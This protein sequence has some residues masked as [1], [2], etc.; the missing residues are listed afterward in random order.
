MFA[1]H[2]VL[3]CRPNHGR[4][5]A[6]DL[7]GARTRPLVAGL[8]WPLAGILDQDTPGPAAAERK[9]SAGELIQTA[10]GTALV[11]GRCGFLFEPLARTCSTADSILAWF[12]GLRASS[13]TFL[14]MPSA[15]APRMSLM[16]HA[17][18]MT[19]GG[20]PRPL[21]SIQGSCWSPAP[22]HSGQQRLDLG[23][24][25]LEVP[26][27]RR[28]GRVAELS[29]E[30]AFAA[31]LDQGPLG[32]GD[33]RVD[34]RHRR[35]GS[36]RRPRRQPPPRG[37]PRAARRTPRGSRARSS[38]GRSTGPVPKHCQS[39]ATTSSSR[40]ARKL[41]GTAS[42]CTR[43][44]DPS[45]QRSSQCRLTL[46]QLVSDVC[47]GRASQRPPATAL[48]GHREAVV[49]QTSGS[50][51]AD[52]RTPHGQTVPE[53][54]PRT[55]RSA[56]RPPS[57][58]SRRSDPRRPPRPVRTGRAPG[59]VPRRTGAQRHLGLAPPVTRVPGV[60]KVWLV[61]R[62]SESLDDPAP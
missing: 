24:L 30:R 15:A 17:Y 13:Y 19:A 44:T 28:D 59:R 60:E 43:P 34:R 50:R 54:E 57:L 62:G 2:V 25:P 16:E 47:Q 33:H 35:A 55:V 23:K 48:L 40:L 18:R 42:P 52:R 36:T 27:V 45:A 3:R 49:E 20:T 39:T 26:D 14:A 9:L 8:R 21:S 5:R 56:A 4:L 31:V 37:R 61:L 12:C 46:P 58:R 29:R 11:Q 51:T 32:P 22:D 38:R 7:E 41:A 6:A 10:T 53:P 1:A